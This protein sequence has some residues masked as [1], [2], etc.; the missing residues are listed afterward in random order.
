MSQ[1]RRFLRGIKP[2]LPDDPVVR[3]ETAPGEQMQVDW[4]E[5]RKGN[6]PLYGGNGDQMPYRTSTK[7]PW[8]PVNRKLAT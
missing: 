3:F 8:P 2:A 6:Q 1:L 4:V 5:F 7:Y